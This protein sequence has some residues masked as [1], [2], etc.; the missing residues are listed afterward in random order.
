[1]SEVDTATTTT[2][3]LPAGHWTIDP[4]HSGIEFGIKHLLITTVKGS[5]NDFEGTIDVTDDSRVSA[6]AAIRAASIDTNEPRRDE[7]LRSGDFFAAEQFP[8]IRFQSTS[9][10]HVEANRFRVAGDLTIKDVTRPL[11]LEAD[12]A[13]S[14]KDPWGNERVGLTLKGQLDPNDFGVDWNQELESGG[15]LIGDRVDFTANISAVKAG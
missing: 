15:N 6:V 14:A 11:E 2:P 4:A 9:V 13:G 8:E 7:H 1:M 12:L 3:V 5:F 10:D